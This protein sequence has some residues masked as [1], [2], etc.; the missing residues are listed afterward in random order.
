MLVWRGYGFVVPVKVL[1]VC[2][3]SQ[4]FLDAMFFKGYYRFSKWPVSVALFIAAVP[5]WLLGKKLN[6]NAEQILFDPRTNQEVKIV[7]THSLFWIRMEYWAP[8]LVVIGIINF[9]H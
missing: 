3:V 6:E 1:F 8:I 7:N 4:Y 2:F 9:V 5:I